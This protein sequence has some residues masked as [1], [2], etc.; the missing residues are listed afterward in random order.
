MVEVKITEKALGDIVAI[1]DF[2]SRDTL[3]F[4][5]I[6]I[7]NLFGSYRKFAKIPRIRSNGS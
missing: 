5:K 3:R 4:S 2:I 7:Q 1:G 6:T